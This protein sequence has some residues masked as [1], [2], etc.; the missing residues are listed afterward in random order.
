MP[1]PLRGNELPWAAGPVYGTWLVHDIVVISYT[2][3]TVTEKLLEYVLVSNIEK[4]GSCTKNISST[5][6]K[7]SYWNHC[8]ISYW[9][10]M[11]V[12]G[13]K[14]F[15]GCLRP[16]RSTWSK[17]SFIFILNVVYR[18]PRVW[19]SDILCT[20]VTHLSR[21]FDLSE[22]LKKIPKLFE[23]SECSS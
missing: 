3:A 4:S 20:V 22:L 14:H 18:R 2:T 9:A 21:T 23:L 15:P 17:K 1:F 5:K 10:K 8:C 16:P 19:A 11:L 7:R 12:A 6:A 13:S